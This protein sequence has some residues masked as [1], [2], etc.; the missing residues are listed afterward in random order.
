MRT[1]PMLT[2][3]KWL[4]RATVGLLAMTAGFCGW[5]AYK[6]S[7]IENHQHEIN[8]RDKRSDEYRHPSGT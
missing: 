1:P 2:E 6:T 8:E 4:M 7:R 3:S 5:I